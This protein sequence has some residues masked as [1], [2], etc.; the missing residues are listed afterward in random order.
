MGT[1]N[2][3][4]DDN[5]ITVELLQG[6]ASIEINST[7]EWNSD[8]QWSVDVPLSNVEPGNYT[9][10]AD[11]GDNTD[12]QNVEIVEELE[13][14]DQTTVDQPENNQTMTTTMTETTTE[15]TTEMTTTQENTTENGSE[16]TSD[17]ESGGSI[18][19]FGVGVA[20]V[21][22]LGAALLALRQN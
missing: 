21:A 11:D 14:P 18:P 20:L 15:T 6:D 8:G 5:T 19:G 2:R 7:D 22:V 10:E 1:T 17:G 9:V 16:G 12:R 13:E 4:A 3:K